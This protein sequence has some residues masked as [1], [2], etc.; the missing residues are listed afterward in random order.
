M[1]IYY[2]K[3]FL[4]C[5][6]DAPEK[7]QLKFYERVRLF[8]VDRFHPLLNNHSLSGEYSGYRSINITG[9]WRALFSEENCGQNIN[10]T[11]LGTH[12]QLYG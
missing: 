4:K 7:I 9:D 1:R 6:G 10:F 12:S 11:D 2:T 5:F 8:N 3:H